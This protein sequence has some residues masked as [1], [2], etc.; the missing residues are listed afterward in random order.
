MVFFNKNHQ[1]LHGHPYWQSIA[2]PDMTLLA[3]SGRLQNAIEV[4]KTGPAGKEFNN[5]VTVW[6]K[7][8]YLCL[9][10]FLSERVALRFVWH[11]Q[12][13]GFLL[14][15][16][17]G[18]NLHTWWLHKSSAERSHSGWW[19]W[20]TRNLS[21][22]RWRP[23]ADDTCH[24]RSCCR[25]RWWRRRRRRR[26]RPEPARHG[27]LRSPRCHDPRRGRPD[28]RRHAAAARWNRLRLL[29]SDK[30]QKGDPIWRNKGLKH[31]FSARLNDS[32][33][34][35]SSECIHSRRVPS[36]FVATKTN[37]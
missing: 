7:I 29:S 27:L 21:M 19:R 1:I 28:A 3:T 12:L 30:E 35:T 15:Y 22:I 18:R 6:H 26:S 16:E 34:L 36:C 32:F 2:T 4:W 33:I 9:Q 25:H 11:H 37:R 13:V 31:Y 20:S 5:S 8:T 24:S 23:S 14:E 10:R 17:Q